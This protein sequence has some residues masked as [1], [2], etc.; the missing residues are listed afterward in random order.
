MDEK[1]KKKSM[2]WPLTR[3]GLG[4]VGAM[5]V[6]DVFNKVNKNYKDEVARLGGK[7][8]LKTK[9]KLAL[10]VA[11]V[12]AGTNFIEGLAEKKME[13]RLNKKAEKDEKALPWAAGRAAGG[14][15]GGLATTMALNDLTE[16][17]Q[18]RL[19]ALKG[20]RNIHKRVPYLLPMAGVAAGVGFT[21]GYLEKGIQKSLT[22]KHKKTASQ[23][24]DT[25][26]KVAKLLNTYKES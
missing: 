2:A 14:A 5:G 10:P 9:A 1:K 7:P 18:D 15:V 4:A 11:G 22:P 17:Y 25:L 12:L 21:K 16:K 13:N 8:S 3:A 6:F 24:L 20:W 23:R 19:K 26:L